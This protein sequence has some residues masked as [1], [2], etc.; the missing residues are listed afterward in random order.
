MSDNLSSF[1]EGALPGVYINKVVLNVANEKWT[2]PFNKNPHIQRNAFEPE[3]IEEAEESTASSEESLDV[4]INFS[5]KAKVPKGRDLMT[6]WLFNQDF[7]GF[8]NIRV[9]SVESE[10]V[11]EG[12]HASNDRIKELVEKKLPSTEAKTITLSDSGLFNLTDEE[13][14]KEY[15][16]D[17][18]KTIDSD[19][20]IIYDIPFS[21]TI[22]VKSVNPDH[23]SLFVIPYLDV[24]K[25]K[26]DF[27]I[28]QDTD[29]EFMLGTHIDEPIIREGKLVTEKTIYRQNPTGEEI[30][31]FLPSPGN[32]VAKGKVWHGPV[33][34]HGARQSG[35]FTGYIGWMGGASHDPDQNQPKLTEDT[36]YNRAMQDFRTLKRVERKVFDFSQIEDRKLGQGV[37][38]YPINDNLNVSR[39]P[40]YFSELFTSRDHEGKCRFFFSVDYLTMIKKNSAFPV[41]FENSDPAIIKE[42]LQKSYIR[43]FKLFRTRISTNAPGHNKL[44][45]KTSVEFDQ[46]TPPQLLASTRDNIVTAGAGS[47]YGGRSGRL[48]PNK[49]IVTVFPG[50]DGEVDDLDDEPRKTIGA[51]REVNL[52]TEDV[53]SDYPF[54]RH[55]TGADHEISE[56]T[57]GSYR[58]DVEIEIEDPT[59]NFLENKLSEL[60]DLTTALEKY[61]NVAVSQNISSPE[62]VTDAV[63]RAGF[64]SAGRRKHKLNYSIVA[65]SFIPEFLDDI[66]QIFSEGSIAED[67]LLFN[68]AKESLNKPDQNNSVTQSMAIKYVSIFELLTRRYTGTGMTGYFQAITLINDI[69]RI[70]D[71]IFGSPEGIGA[72]LRLISDLSI[73]LERMLN[74]KIS[75][76]VIK[77]APDPE[78]AGTSPQ[79]LKIDATRTFKVIKEFSNLE[80]VFDSDAPKNF[81]VDYLTSDPPVSDFELTRLNTGDFRERS[82]LEIRKY[83]GQESILRLDKDYQGGVNLLL[84][85][86]RYAYFSPMSI[87]TRKG[88]TYGLLSHALKQ[89][90]RFYEP[91]RYNQILVDALRY[92]DGL[93]IEVD[94]YPVGKNLV[95]EAK[96]MQ[97]LRGGLIDFMADKSCTVSSMKSFNVHVENDKIE[98]LCGT[99]STIFSDVIK[100]TPILDMLPYTTPVIGYDNKLSPQG[101]YTNDLTNP[102]NILFKLSSYFSHPTYKFSPYTHFDIRHS[103]Q[104]V[105]DID[106]SGDLED[107]PNQYKAMIAVG[108]QRKMPKSEHDLVIDLDRDVFQKTSRTSDEHLKQD[109]LGFFYLNFMNLCSVEVLTGYRVIDGS[110]KN[111]AQMNEPFFERIE[112][113]QWETINNFPTDDPDNRIL[114]RLKR[115]SNLKLNIPEI[116]GFEFPIY[117]KHFLMK[118]G[119]PQKEFAALLALGPA[120]QSPAAQILAHAAATATP[121]V[122]QAAADNIQAVHLAAQL[123]TGIQMGPSLPPSGFTSPGLSPG[124]MPFGFLPSTAQ[125]VPA[126]NPAVQMIGGMISP[127]PGTT[128]IPLAAS[129]LPGGQTPLV[130]SAMMSAVQGGIFPGMAANAKSNVKA[131]T[132]HLAGANNPITQFDSQGKFIPGWSVYK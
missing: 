84:A 61:Y 108:T 85:P 59:V 119:P 49:R 93:N 29:I 67:T 73:S 28:T 115:H 8:Y 103:R 3:W 17:F 121:A 62:T 118:I 117:N 79:S 89:S 9:V 104:V 86:Q 98:D 10:S 15:I 57:N 24:D 4:F 101:V 16:K 25:I 32:P 124:T 87:T 46:E 109:S 74:T 94:P 83:F 60:V 19:G 11:Y 68:L 54:M 91:D 7:I 53:R 123:G 35:D 18:H 112:A 110:E 12:I 69:A 90:N 48:K 120:P 75:G 116:K 41:L 6:S 99:Q 44:G 43:S 97:R 13:D 38:T 81:G 77:E 27:G 23:L 63:S 45:T 82:N 55:F 40:S 14:I 37:I 47:G 125:I 71:P 65:Q 52:M 66:V 22:K 105:F 33:H 107:L 21:H 2:S 102:N 88:A 20:N 56:F 100:F 106:V 58:Y 26:K 31:S 111:E 130:S 42:L 36:V 50:L 126:L 96:A 80:D 131:A 76:P 122:L 64:Y 70:I 127:S 5:L 51:V 92:N 132:F 129:S 30:A 95:S 128:N 113:N 39:I 1:F 72:F 114:C 34:Y 78:F